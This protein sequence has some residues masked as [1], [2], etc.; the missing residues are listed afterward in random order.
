MVPGHSSSFLLMAEHY[1]VWRVPQVGE[2]SVSTAEQ[3]M[4]SR[5]GLV[6]VNL[7]RTGMHRFLS[8]FPGTTG[9]IISAYR[10]SGETA[11]D[12]AWWR[13]H[14]PFLPAT[15][16]FW[17]LQAASVWHYL[18][19]FVLDIL[20]GL[21]CYLLC[22]LPIFQLDRLLGGFLTVRFLDSTICPSLAGY[23]NIVSQSVTCHFSL[24]KRSLARSKFE[25]RPAYQFFLLWIWVKSNK[26]FDYT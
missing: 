3:P 8:H 9:C 25:L 12:F 10:V 23:V 18:R 22:L 19:F 24:F 5:L 26:Y 16:L 21:C 4:I 6:H 2:P 20:I 13:L 14:F 17:I 11:H 7:L 1:S 15:W